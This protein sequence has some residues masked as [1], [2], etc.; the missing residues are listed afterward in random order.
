M[1]RSDLILLVK[2]I[3]QKLKKHA[4]ECSDGLHKIEFDE[5]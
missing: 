2:S 4:K 3:M 5:L 1:N